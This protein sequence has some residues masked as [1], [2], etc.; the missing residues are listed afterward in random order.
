MV[1]NHFINHGYMDKQKEYII[2]RLLTYIMLLYN[3][4]YPLPNLL[5]YSIFH[6]SYS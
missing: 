1:I 5:S 4:N 2:T 3:H 6:L